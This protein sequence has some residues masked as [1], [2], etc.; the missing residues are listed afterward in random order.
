M[1]SAA[2]T[3]G[4]SGY[5]ISNSLRFRQSAS[6]YLSRTFATTGTSRQKFTFSFWIKRGALTTASQQ[7]I[8]DCYDGSS[9]ASTLLNFETNDTL[10]FS[11]G[12]GS[13][14]IITTT[15]VFRDPSAWYHIV[16]AV[17]TTQA[18]AANRGILYVNGSQV[19]S[20]STATYPTQN[21]NCD[22]MYNN[23][24]N[25]IMAQWS[26]GSGY[27]DG[28]LAEVNFIDG[29]QLTPSSFGSTNATT[30]VWQPAKYTGT[31]GTNGFYLKFDDTSA[32]TAAAIGKDSSG[33]GNNWTPTNISVTA[34]TTYD[35]MTDSPTLTSPTA[36]NYATMNPLS[37]GSTISIVDG[38]LKVTESSS[39]G[40]G[41]NSTI[42]VNSGKYYWEVTVLGVEGGNAY[43]R[44]GVGATVEQTTA[45]SFLTALGWR[46]DGTVSAGGSSYITVNGSPGGTTFTTND[47]IQVALDMDNNKVWLGKNNT[48]LASGNPA[49][50]ANAT[51]TITAGTLMV[52]TTGIYTS[53]SIVA[54]NFGQRPFSYTAPSGY[55][56][57]NTFNLPNSTIVKGNSYMDATLYTGT[58]A[59]LTVT[60]AAGFKP[61]LVWCKARSLAYYHH[62]VDSV[63]GVNR[64]LNSNTTDAEY[65]YSTNGSVTSF[66][67]NGFS[68]GTQANEINTNAGTFVGWQWQAGQGSTSSNT[69]G[70]I[71]STVSVNTTAG[72][73]IVTWTSP[74]VV[75]T[76]W[77]V[78]HGLG[79]A[80]AMTIT[81]ER[82][83]VSGWT[84][85]HKSLGATKSLNLSST[86]AT[87]T[88]TGLFNNTE[89]TSSVMTFGGT[90]GASYYDTN[91]TQVTYAWA[92]IAGFS[93]FTSYT[94]NGSADGPFTYLGFLP[95]Y[96]MIKCSS[97]AGFNWYVWDSVRNTYNVLGEEL[98]P[99]LSDAALTQTD[100][101]I[102]A[103]GFKIRTTAGR[104]NSS[105][106]TYIVAAFA[107]NPFKN[108]NAF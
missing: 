74:A 67:S 22:W 88:S 53:S 94:G 7:R 84:V 62:L 103:N 14:A 89:P 81:K 104:V 15:Q 25:R 63:R 23:A 11:W 36:A 41:T 46:P 72:F 78:G 3:S 61:D 97:S 8:M 91:T 1:F 83:A 51:A 37:K 98:E 9:G 33:N 12:N 105:G 49:T 16:I 28:Y 92:E 77:T 48:W 31:Y 76:A 17:D 38:N 65:Y 40:S 54:F 69:S 50:G 80:P 6:A 5:K 100:L 90:G 71:T 4:P 47:I 29:Q 106:A 34:G 26:G 86:N 66:N 56:P 45:N 68:L 2:K 58:G 39:S 35:A 55:L 20:F 21:L 96:L 44:I 101:D 64:D 73:S 102:T 43:P 75:T 70:S 59:N 93:K 18:T 99:N 57:L 27:A 42:S 13:A 24:N 79:V 95:K 82:G 60:N 107:S 32:A 52:A 10:S 87:T 108:S 19:T 85:Y 30:G